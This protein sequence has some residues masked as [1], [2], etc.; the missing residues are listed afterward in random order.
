MTCSKEIAKCLPIYGDA[1]VRRLT[2]IRRYR[3][4]GF[5]IDKVRLLVSLVQNRERSCKEARDLAFAK[6]TELRRSLLNCRN[7]NAA[8]QPSWTAVTG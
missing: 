1:G 8:S 7:W 5:P 3:D 6:L 2:L 4:F